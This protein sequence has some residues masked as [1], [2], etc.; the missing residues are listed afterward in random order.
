[1]KKKLQCLCMG[2]LCMVLL[3]SSALAADSITSSEAT[4]V[5]QGAGKKSNP[6]ILTV[7]NTYTIKVDKEL[8]SN[9]YL[10]ANWLLPGDNADYLAISGEN[11]GTLSPKIQA[12]ASSNG[13][14]VILA[15][16][17]QICN[18][19]VDL[20]V[21]TAVDYYYFI[22]QDRNGTQ[23]GNGA[24]NGNSTQGGNSTNEKAED[25]QQPTKQPD[26][27]AKDTETSSDKHDTAPTSSNSSDHS[28]TCGTGVTWK[29]EGDT[30]TVSGSGSMQIPY[31]NAP[32]KSYNDEIKTVTIQSGITS[33]GSTT[34]YGCKNLENILIPDTVS[35][36]KFSAFEN[37]YALE[38]L[39]LPDS[40]KEIDSFLFHSCSSLKSLDIP[41]GV[42]KIGSYAF[43]GCTS[44]ESIS[45]PSS[46]TEIDS[47][48]FLRCTSLQ[49]IY[50]GGT[51]AQ[52]NRI[53]IGT[54]N[55][56]LDSATLHAEKSNSSSSGTPIQPPLSDESDDKSNDVSDKLYKD[57]WYANAMN[58]AQEN[59]ITQAADYRTP[60]AR[61]SRSNVTL[62]LWRAAGC[63]SVKD[64]IASFIDIS[65]DVAYYDAL[66]WAVS[67][68]IING[69]EDSSFRPDGTVTRAQLVTI[70]Y[71][72]QN[73]GKPSSTVS[74]SDVPHGAWFEE[75]VQWAVQNSITNG[76]GSGKFS[77]DS[78][79]TTAQVITFLYRLD[80]L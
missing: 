10:D 55:K 35:S 56:A 46:V 76:T 8:G 26:K 79:C 4:D 78:A 7:G 52:W 68:K 12:T 37:C 58:W 5:V 43:S 23:G 71:R 61:C 72:S 62:F 49:D 13:K 73:A 28:G 60:D 66:Q 70:L 1:M 44:L 6:W 77:P 3:L 67:E 15:L 29:L 40:I 9:E 32:W 65:P 19:G 31:Q 41:Y 51:E 48:A 34:F 30:L 11:F 17:H 24:Q 39:T 22:V 53:T 18:V 38:Y 45:I 63:P 25:K 27:P 33:I 75:S 59:S 47:D 50:Y 80:N 69:F 42:T 21:W 74:F 57:E 54:N 2:I 14:T 16:Q 20:D 36:I 64:G